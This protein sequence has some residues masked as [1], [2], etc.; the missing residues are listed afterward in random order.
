MFND[1]N[2]LLDHALRELQLAVEEEMTEVE[3]VLSYANEGKVNKIMNSHEKLNVMKV[4][5]LLRLQYPEYYIKS[6]VGP[7]LTK[8][9]VIEIPKISKVIYYPI[10][11]RLSLQ[12]K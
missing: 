7:K 4:T 6:I 3:I 9:M 8:Q 2:E 5:E 10:V 11:W 12:K 1:S